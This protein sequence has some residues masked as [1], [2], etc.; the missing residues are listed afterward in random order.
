MRKLH[1][2]ASGGRRRPQLLHREVHRAPTLAPPTARLRFLAWKVNKAAAP[3]LNEAHPSHHHHAQWWWW[4]WWPI[5]AVIEL[6]A[7]QQTVLIDEG[8]RRLTTF[9]SDE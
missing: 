3:F 1:N 4:W 5:M 7:E 8:T 6:L 9:G 2:G